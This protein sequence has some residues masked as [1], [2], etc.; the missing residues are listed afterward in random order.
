MKNKLKA[1]T[2]I[3]G[4]IIGIITYW[5]NSYN[6]SIAFGYNIYLL[7]AVLS[8]IAPF[9]IGFLFKTRTYNIPLFI[10]VGFLFAVLSRIFFDIFKDSTSHNLFPFEIIFTLGVAVPFSLTGM[11][12]S[13]F[14]NKKKLWKN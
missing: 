10:C 13:N 6:Q 1:I 12:I 7:M 5:F 2:F 11:Y 9:F 14:I 8:F 3:V 4:F